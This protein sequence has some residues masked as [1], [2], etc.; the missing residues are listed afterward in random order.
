MFTSFGPAKFDITL[1]SATIQLCM[2]LTATAN[3]NEFTMYTG[4]R[5]AS[6][7]SGVTL[8]HDVGTLT[9]DD[10]GT[11]QSHS[12]GNNF[13]GHAW[14]GMSGSFSDDGTGSGSITSSDNPTETNG[15]WVADGTGMP[16]PQ[17]RKAGSVHSA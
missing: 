3:P 17:R 9:L 13:G 6:S 10:D 8:T 4:D 12:F 5:G 16:V 15:Q 14:S 2:K 11:I 7:C 1:G